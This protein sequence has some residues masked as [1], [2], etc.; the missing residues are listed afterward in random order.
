MSTVADN[1][2][3]MQD[4]AKMGYD[5]SSGSAVGSAVAPRLPKEEPSLSGTAGTVHLFLA[6]IF[7]KYNI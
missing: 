3:C 6:G 7:D 1:L 4:L 2:L 5:T